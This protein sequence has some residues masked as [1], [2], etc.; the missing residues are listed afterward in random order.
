MIFYEHNY[1]PYFNMCIVKM[2]VICVLT[3]KMFGKINKQ[4]GPKGPRSLT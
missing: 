3:N 1:A 4:E 2:V